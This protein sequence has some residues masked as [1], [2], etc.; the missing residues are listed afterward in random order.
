MEGAQSGSGLVSWAMRI[1]YKSIGQPVLWMAGSAIL[2]LLA[3]IGLSALAPITAEPPQP[4]FFLSLFLSLAF[5]IGLVTLTISFNCWLNLK[6]SPLGPIAH[7]APE[8]RTRPILP[9]PERAT[10]R[11]GNL[12]FIPP[13]PEAV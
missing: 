7:N 5:E 4:K 6:M 3:F 12:Q 2:V 1:Q 8:A 10:V 9:S 13:S 11:S